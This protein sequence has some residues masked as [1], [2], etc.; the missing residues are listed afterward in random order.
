MMQMIKRWSLKVL[1]RV[2]IFLYRGTG[3]SKG[4]RLAGMPI[5]LLTTTGRKSVK[6]PTVPLGYLPDGPNYVLTGSNAGQD[7]DPAWILNLRSKPQASIQIQ[8]A[9][10]PVVAEQ[11]DSSERSR[12]WAQLIA[13]TPVYDTYRRK[14]LREIPMMILRP[15][16]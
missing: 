15:E 9:Q 13:R 14:T 5:L 10:T 4:S 6:R 8:R 2:H 12:L 11:A 3:G 16:S 7:R 1:S